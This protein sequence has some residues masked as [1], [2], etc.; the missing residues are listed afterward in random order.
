MKATTRIALPLILFAC[1]VFISCSSDHSDDESVSPVRVERAACYQA[2]DYF[3]E[4]LASAED[5]GSA[6]PP[7]PESSP[8]CSSSVGLGEKVPFVALEEA[9]GGNTIVADSVTWAVSDQA[10]AEISAD[11]TLS[12]FGPGSVEVRACVEDLCSEPYPITA[13]EDPQVVQL[14]IFPGYYYPVP[15][16]ADIGITMPD[17]FD[18]YFESTLRLLV[19]DTAEFFARGVLE[20]GSWVDLTTEVAWHS[21]D[22]DV[23]TLDSGGLLTAHA[24]GNTA[25]TATYESLTSNTVEVEVLAEAILVDL[26]VYRQSSEGILKVGSIDQFHADAYYDP[27][28]LNDVTN[29]VEWVISDPTLASV[30]PEGI[31]TALAPGL[32]TVQARYQGKVSNEIAME[33][34]DEVEMDYCDPANPHRAFW[35]DEYNRVILETDCDTYPGQSPV[36][37]RYTI[38]ENQPHPWG[39]LDPCLDLVVLNGADQVVKTLRFEGCGDLPFA[40]EAGAL[41]DFDPI[42]QYGTVWDRTDDDG[43]PVP[44]GVYAI[45]GRF[46]IYYDP[47][48]RLSISLQE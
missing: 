44:A 23:A 20:T 27:W 37:I 10:V 33:I 31:L 1:A 16:F 46:Y 41:A 36:R 3:P 35:E 12:F 11:G 5:N 28:M 8:F 40:M 9:G 24:Q 2:L 48:I 25:V 34:W 13:V 38:E 30:S 18:C 47:V 22:A 26:Y 43:Q 29:E 6:A 21:T 14:E 4:V 15:L 7:A 42:Y 45:A 39:I 19:G 32:L 17:C